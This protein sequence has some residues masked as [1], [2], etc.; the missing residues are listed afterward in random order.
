MA[1]KNIEESRQGD[2]SLDTA[3]SHDSPVRNELNNMSIKESIE[4]LNSMTS[5]GNAPGLTDLSINFS[6]GARDEAGTTAKT[7]E[8]KLQADAPKPG[9]EKPAQGDNQA[10]L[11]GS[12][13]IP[14]KETDAF[15][16]GSAEIRDGLKSSERE[17]SADERK[18]VDRISTEFG[19]KFARGIGFSDL[20]TAR[21]LPAV[22]DKL[23]QYG[24]GAHSIAKELNRGLQ[25]SGTR[26]QVAA[27]SNFEDNRVEL[28][29][30]PGVK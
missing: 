5:R 19:N 25:A 10:E 6:S 29:K 27:F 13:F 3:V 22:V 4:R 26:T 7:K 20:D 17:L 18:E 24:M 1:G 28:R 16:Q 2:K 8:S 14:R 30:L 21:E 15:G 9:R 23:R 11:P 12:Q